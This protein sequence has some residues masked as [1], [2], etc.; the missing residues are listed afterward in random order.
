[1]FS[2]AKQRAARLVLLTLF[3]AFVIGFS[4][5]VTPVTPPSPTGM[6]TSGGTTC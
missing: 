4:P 1:M 5:V 3:A 2:R 6:C